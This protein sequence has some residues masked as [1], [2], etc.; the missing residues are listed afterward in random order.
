MSK[1]TF[2]N[3]LRLHS[4]IPRKA[5]ATKC[6]VFGNMT[7]E[8]SSCSSSRQSRTSLRTSSH[9]STATRPGPYPRWLR[10]TV[11]PFRHGQL[12]CNAWRSRLWCPLLERVIC[13]CG[14]QTPRHQRWIHSEIEWWWVKSTKERRKR[15]CEINKSFNWYFDLVTHNNQAASRLEERSATTEEWDHDAHSSYENKKVLGWQ[16]QVVGVECSVALV[17]EMKP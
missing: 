16:T 12:C 8:P 10:L 17:G 6:D 1:P 11:T 2:Y 5:L 15:D 4:R 14:R 3:H 13:H 9:R 7:L